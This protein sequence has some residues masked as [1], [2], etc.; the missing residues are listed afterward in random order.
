MSGSGKGLL[1]LWLYRSGEQEWAVKEGSPLHKRKEL[2]V[3]KTAS[4]LFWPIWSAFGNLI[5]QAPDT[6]KQPPAEAVTPGDKTSIIFTLNNQVGGL[7]RALQVFQELG[8]NVLHLELQN[9]NPSVEQVRHTNIG[10]YF[11]V[12]SIFIGFGTGGRLRGHR[13]RSEAFGESNSP[14]EARS[15]I[16][17][18]CIVG[19]CGRRLS[20]TDAAVSVLVV[21]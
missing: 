16:G 2:M 13:M 4:L 18:L 12:N 5:L 8:I 9:T 10:D 21:W 17:E 11:W 15:E 6:S 20:T 14:A 1:G 19:A 7:A 3:R